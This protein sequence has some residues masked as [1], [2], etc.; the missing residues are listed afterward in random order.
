MAEGVTD[1]SVRS[2]VE[3]G[4]IGRGQIENRSEVILAR[5]R[6]QVVQAHVLHLARG[7]HLIN[8][9]TYRYFSVKR[10]QIHLYSSYGGRKR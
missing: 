9:V 3:A 1:L 5:S 10:I 4:I 2:Q 7:Q 8:V 6:G